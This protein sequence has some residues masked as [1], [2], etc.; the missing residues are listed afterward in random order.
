MARETEIEEFV[1]HYGGENLSISD[2]SH[3][4]DFP[5]SFSVRIKMTGAGFK[6]LIANYPSLFEV[7][8]PDEIADAVAGQA[9]EDDKQPPFDLLPPEAGSPAVCV[10]DSGMQEGHRWLAAAVDQPRSHCFVPGEAPT[11]VADYVKGGGHGTKVAGASLYAATVPRTGSI[12]APFW[13]QNARVLDRSN[14]LQ[15][16]I[17]PAELL[18]EVVDRYR[19]EAN[20]RIYNH[21][22]T[23]NCCCRTSRMTSWAAT[24]DF[25]SF[26]EDALFI[27]AAGNLPEQTGSPIRPGIVDHIAVGRGYPDYLLENSSRIANPAQSLQ[28]LTVGSV[29]S[30]Y[31]KDDDRISVAPPFQASAFSRSGFGLWRSIKPDVVEFGGDYAIGSG[32]P[33]NLT[34]PP[35]VCP[36]L[37]RSTLYGGPAVG[38]DDIGTSFAAPKVAH[39][40]GRLAGLFP[41]HGTQLYRALIVN[42][43]RW[44]AWP[45]RPDARS[46]RA[47]CG[48]SVMAFQIRTVR[49]RTP[50]TGSC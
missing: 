8:A 24:I 35:E 40:A 27:Q 22:I 12:Q 7:A 49:R 14:S 10:I 34:T 16:R 23:A 1:A 29:A 43:A 30:D 46:G 36:E 3:I 32:T 9:P 44:P 47:L 28:A 6:D 42:S 18:R 2:E 37:I 11:D 39:I 33:P 38:R 4:V 50:P 41:E 13:V 25:L 17:F 21:S 31:Y 5:D 48:R 15:E 26:S 20:T 45:K 19:T